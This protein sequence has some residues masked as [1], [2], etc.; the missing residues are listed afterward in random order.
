MCAMQ[1]LILWE[2][3][4]IVSHRKRL[5]E[6]EDWRVQTAWLSIQKFSVKVP[7][8]EV[9]ILWSYSSEDRRV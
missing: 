8:L 7:V 2:M 6:E 9:S 1:E 3:W 4:K 5:L